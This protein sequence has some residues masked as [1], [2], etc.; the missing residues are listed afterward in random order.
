MPRFGFSCA[1]IDAGRPRL[2]MTF[3][4]AET[5]QMVRAPSSPRSGVGASRL[6]AKA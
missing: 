1:L 5:Y 6:L 4:A 2:E 3:V